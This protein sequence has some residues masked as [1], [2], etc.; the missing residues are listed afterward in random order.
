MLS[1]KENFFRT[2]SGDIPE[3]VPSRFDPYLRPFQEELLTPNNLPDGQP[4]VTSLGVTYVGCREANNGAMPKPGEIVI[5][6]ITK[7]RDQLKILNEMPGHWE[8]ALADRDWEGYYKSFLDKVDREK[9]AVSVSGGDYFLTLVSLLGFENTMLAMMEEPEEVQALLTEISEFY[10][11]VMKKELQYMKPDVF[12]LMDDDAAF[13]CPFFS[14][15]TYREIF[16]PFHKMHCDLALENGCRLLRH[17]C[18]KSEQFVD[19]W[20]ELGI[21]A[22]NPFQVSN[23][24][25]RIK[26]EYGDRLTLDGAWDGVSVLNYSDDELIAALDE[27]AATF[28]PGGRFIFAASAGFLLGDNHRTEVIRDYYENN[29]RY[30]YRYH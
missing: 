24:C 11:F 23:D 20:L 12:N 8:Q 26:K 9:T 2:L 4:F 30:Y 28:L 27:Y 18:G 29:V 10:L 21:E 7:W 15:D 13:L 25:K 19:D 6:D 22:W 17:D 16:K 5:S 1:P 3:Y 14:V